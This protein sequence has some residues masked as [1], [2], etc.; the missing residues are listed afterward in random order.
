MSELE[1]KALQGIKASLDEL[2]E[3]VQTLEAELAIRNLMTRYGLAAD[4]GEAE[5]AAD[6]FAEDGLYTVAAPRAGRSGEHDDL[7]L[8]GRAAIA[9]ML[10]SDLHQSMLP[11]TAHTTGPSEFCIEND[12]A[13]ATATATAIGYSRIYLQEEGSPRLMRL[14]VNRWR[15]IK[16]GGSWK[17]RE[18]HSHL[19]G[20]EATA[21]MLRSALMT[22]SPK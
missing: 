16:T 17:I 8:E 20:D 19:V 5:I 13:T 12:T 15:F 3:R 10:R 9:D 14:A 4:C 21:S 2:N 18:R 1:A 7:V 22:D 6:C 11:F